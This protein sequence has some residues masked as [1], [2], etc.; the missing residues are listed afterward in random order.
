MIQEPV[1]FIPGAYCD[2]EIFAPQIMDLG[3]DFDVMIKRVLSADRAIDAARQAALHLPR[4]VALV[5]YGLGGNIALE[6]ARLAPDHISRIALISSDVF[7]EQPKEAAAREHRI[8]E[9]RSG[10]FQD[11][12]RNE[13]AAR[14]GVGAGPAL[15]AH[16]LYPALMDMAL[17]VGE[18]RILSHVRLLQRRADQQSNLRKLMLPTAIISGMNDP[19]V[20]EKRA[21]LK[22][23]LTPH[24]RLTMIE[25][26]GHYPTWQAAGQVNAALRDWLAMPAI[27]ER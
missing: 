11:A 10:R 12:M 7:A 21:R 22:A 15:D 2:V 27:K 25:N 24:A 9:L 3:R 23:Q 17:R 5:G 8:I 14:L 20:L 1:Y 13:F 6:L 4:K 16:P 26:C 19:L 18:K